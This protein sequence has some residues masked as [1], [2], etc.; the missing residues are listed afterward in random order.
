LN[1]V[2]IS[3]KRNKRYDQRLIHGAQQKSENHENLEIEILQ[4]TSCKQSRALA[5]KESID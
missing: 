3:I 1:A 2:N 5:E 4:G